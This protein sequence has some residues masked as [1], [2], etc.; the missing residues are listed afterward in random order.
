MEVLW[1]FFIKL[2]VTILM[3]L[4]L[5]IIA[6]KVSPKVSGIISGIPTGTAIILFFYAIEQGTDFAIKSA[7]FNLAGMFSMHV[8]IYL[9]FRFSNEDSIHSALKASFISIM[10]YSLS[11]FVLN[12]L[13]PGLT[14]SIILPILSI[15]LFSYLFRKIKD[16]KIKKIAKLNHQVLIVRTFI[17][18]FFIILITIIAGLVGPGWAGLFSVFPTTLF[19]LILII[20]LTYGHD[21]VH[22]I[23]KNV[24]KGSWAI[25]IYVFGISIF[26]GMFGVIVGTL[27][28]YL[29]VFIYLILLFFIERR[30]NKT[31]V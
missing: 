2:S 15:F 4:T 23:I 22:S 5:T 24:P 18:S 8:F 17:A 14:L 30:V 20:H 28:S 12:W 1:L 6:E 25:L 29:G 11:I 3:V 9:Y 26:Y 10:G 21:K 16:L 27:I 31:K 19:P 13:N 7:Y